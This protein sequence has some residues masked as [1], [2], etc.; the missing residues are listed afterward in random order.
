[1]RH[2]IL[3][4]C[5]LLSG[6]AGLSY[7]LLWVRMLALSFGSTTLSF[8]TVLAVFF[9]GLALG[10]WLAGRLLA[11]ISRP[12]LVYGLIELITGLLGLALYPLLQRL[13]PIFAALDPG[14]DL[15]GAL[16]RLAVAAPILLLPTVLMGAT[17]PIISKAMIERDEKVGR[18]TGLIYGINTFGAFAA[19]Y[20]VTYHLIY[21]LGVFG[22]IL[23]TVLINV[24][25][26]VIAFVED[27]R[28]RRS[29]ITYD[30]PSTEASGSTLEIPLS[31]E[32]R[33]V[34]LMAN[35]LT[36]ISG[37]AFIGFE[38]VWARLFSIALGGTVY[39][40]GAVLVC[41]LVGI[42]VGSIVVSYTADRRGSGN[43]FVA[44]Q[45]LAAAGI[46]FV[47][48]ALPFVTY[49]I[50][51]I[52]LR[53][54][55]SFWPQHLQLLL[56][57]L[58]LLIPTAAT[59]ASFPLL[60]KVVT[61]GAGSVGRRLGSLYAVNTVG[62]IT[63][64]LLTGFVVLPM[65]GSESTIY[66]GLLLLALSAAL[67]ATFLMRSSGRIRQLV[68]AAL[69]VGLVGLYS[70]IDFPSLWAQGDPLA[71][72]DQ[73]R[74]SQEANA[75]SVVYRAE[76]KSALVQVVRVPTGYAL[77][78]NRL[79][80]GTI[81]QVP[82]RYN[83]ES[84]LVGLI[85][86]AHQPDAENALVVGFGA[87]A[88]VELL[89]RMGVPRVRVVE[90][91][92]EV[93]DA[94]DVIFQGKSPLERPGVEFE[95]NDARHALLV[96]LRTNGPKY[97][98]ITSMPS[99]PWVASSIFTKEFF[100]VARDN[101]KPDGVFSTW[102]GMGRMD[103]LAVQSLLRA[104][105][106]VFPHYTVY[107]VREA[108]AYYLVG[109]MSPRPI[110]PARVSRLAAHEALVEH[111]VFREPFYLEARVVASADANSPP[112]AP[113]I[114]NTDDSAFVEMH[115]PR[116]ST[117]SG[118][119]ADF[120]PHEYLIPSA[121][122]PSTPGF[123]LELAEV[124]LGTPG[125]QL[126]VRTLPSNPAR[127]RNMLRGSVGGIL[128]ADQRRY[129][130]ARVALLEGRPDRARP[131]LAQVATSS[132]AELAARARKFLAVTYDDVD[133]R[134]QAMLTELPPTSDVVARLLDL[135]REV[136]LS[137]LRAGPTAPA[138]DL[139]RLLFELAGRPTGGVPLPEAELARLM[140]RHVMGT[141]NL[142][143]L[144][145]C[146]DYALRE[147]RSTLASVCED[148]SQRLRR[149]RSTQFRDRALAHLRRRDAQ[150]GLR[151]L[152]T[153]V[154]LAPSR[155]LV[156]LVTRA[157]ID[158]GREAELDALLAPIR[159][160]T[161]QHVVD[162]LVAEVRARAL[163]GNVAAPYDPSTPPASGVSPEP[164]SAGNGL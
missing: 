120:L 83:V 90:L 82:P 73:H 105:S 39:G 4:F 88:T 111:E 158:A 71:N 97:H 80:Q 134:R 19:S 141:W 22:S 34:L 116:S 55:G 7:E 40:V 41:F 6:F 43:M 140:R 48:A 142:G 2:H 128:G 70:G 154:E 162:A 86:L 145:L 157:A 72:Y 114:V 30:A 117:S 144:R 29:G 13:G 5:L 87:G 69:A 160:V 139:G 31:E 20:L 98:I 16:V 103:G 17:L 100:E 81:S 46:L 92:R 77:T 27:A 47:S 125:G 122:E 151:L 121:I 159:L 66:L 11:R 95:V 89:S 44:L 110:T 112:T 51:V 25:V 79:G 61:Q 12:V 36:F 26:A 37:F 106:S 53:P 104:F 84:A 76:G 123:Y 23:A 91:E 28:G 3:L 57:F 45:L 35:V 115:S 52:G 150:T 126:P 146:R 62:S 78:L 24:L 32:D 149:E 148:E 108:G 131:A 124:L 38:V 33:K 156:A 74:K 102:F 164:G 60:V 137:R 56:V 99:H 63:G 65:M 153:A 101:L 64:S 136:A 135:D 129:L 155:D 107:F 54:R 21:G 67:G 113:G 14:P 10:S 119:L 75:K 138:D 109:S 68:A 58:V 147:G 42:A 152:Q 18:G 127:V 8:S 9:G 93:I 118:V 130:E 49:Q 85:P 143:L 1:M 163:A 94:A 96:N 50:E 15:S 132:V 161:E 59:G 133:P